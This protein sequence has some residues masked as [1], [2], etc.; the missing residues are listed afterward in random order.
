MALR[1]VKSCGPDAPMLGFNAAP[2]LTRCAG[3]GGKKARFTRES[4]KQPLKTIAQ[5]VPDR[6]GRPVVTTLVCFLFCIRGCGRA[7][8]PAFPAPSLGVAVFDTSV[9]FLLRENAEVRHK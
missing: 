4:T 6:I 3:D 9:A 8:R 2:T 5:G 7:D 1:T